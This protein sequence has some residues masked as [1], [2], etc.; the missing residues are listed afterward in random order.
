MLQSLAWPLIKNYFRQYTSTLLSLV[1][2]TELYIAKIYICA[3]SS[4]N[5]YNCLFCNASDTNDIP[6][7]R[8]LTPCNTVEHHA[9]L[10]PTNLWLTLDPYRPYLP[11]RLQILSK[12]CPG[13][14]FF[15]L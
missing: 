15:V 14:Y 1:Q 4:L 6:V 2:L 11:V 12:P 10:K 3:L 8:T 5:D 13:Y 7:Q 9:A